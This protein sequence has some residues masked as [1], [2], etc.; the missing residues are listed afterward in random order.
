MRRRDLGRLKDDEGVAKQVCGGR[1]VAGKRTVREKVPNMLT[2]EGRGR[3]ELS[4]RGP[5]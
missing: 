1:A 3:P 5:G 4:S 2:R